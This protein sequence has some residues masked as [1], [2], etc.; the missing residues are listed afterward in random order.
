MWTCLPRSS[1]APTSR[2]YR[3][4]TCTPSPRKDRQET[5]TKYS[6]TG[7]CQSCENLITP[8]HLIYPITFSFDII[9]RF[10]PNKG[11]RQL[12]DL[13]QLRVLATC[14]ED[15]ENMQLAQPILDAAHNTLEEIKL[16]QSYVVPYSDSDGTVPYILAPARMLTSLKR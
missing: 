6:W 2:T 12:A 8:S 3:Y 10:L 1:S 13:S 16:Q 14:R 9:Q 15:E 7:H 4:T 11:A 5:T